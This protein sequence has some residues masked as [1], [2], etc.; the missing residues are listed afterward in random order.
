ML[1]P[2]YLGPISSFEIIMRLFASQSSNKITYIIA[3]TRHCS[4][5]NRISIIILMGV[6]L[7]SIAMFM[8]EFNGVLLDSYVNFNSEPVVNSLQDVIDNKQLS[9]FAYLPNIEK[10][11][12]FNL[13]PEAAES[14][15]GRIK[16]FRNETN[17]TYPKDFK[18]EGI[19]RQLIKGNL[20]IICISM[21]R[22]L[23][24]ER[25]RPWNKFFTLAR[26]MYSA[27]NANFRVPKD[28]PLT[29][30]LVFM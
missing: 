6:V 2:F 30:I 13:N 12:H 11:I 4:F 14:L 8:R 10:N 24:F 1:A 21:A 25:F 16:K 15:I 9:I 18:D 17:L 5:L 7:Q 26:E 28:K 22:E 27:N 23:Y 29:E 20:V 3:Q 19:F